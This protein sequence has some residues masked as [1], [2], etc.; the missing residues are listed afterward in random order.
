[1]ISKLMKQTGSIAHWMKS[2][3]CLS[4]TIKIRSD[5]D[6]SFY[7]PH[8]TVF[9]EGLSQALIQRSSGDFGDLKEIMFLYRHISVWMGFRMTLRKAKS[10]TIFKN[11]FLKCSAGGKTGVGR[12]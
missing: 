8:E 10:E 9:E 7:L 3:L 4:Q 6:C 11:F 5:Q 2:K 12:Q 1:M